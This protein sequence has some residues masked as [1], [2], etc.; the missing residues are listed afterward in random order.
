MV[1]KSYR[2]L[3][4]GYQLYGIRCCDNLWGDVEHPVIPHIAKIILYVIEPYTGEVFEI[5]ILC[6]R[7]DI[8]E[9][10]GPVL[11]HGN[12]L[13]I[14]VLATHDKHRDNEDKGKQERG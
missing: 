8:G 6:V 14:L 2:R 10:V 5:S 12:L 9:Q 7:Y 4:S 1:K 11:N 3:L 13:E